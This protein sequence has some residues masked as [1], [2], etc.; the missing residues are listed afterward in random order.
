MGKDN[1]LLALIGKWTQFKSEGEGKLSFGLLKMIGDTITYLL[2]LAL[3]KDKE[4]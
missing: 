2:E 4:D 3:I 1:R